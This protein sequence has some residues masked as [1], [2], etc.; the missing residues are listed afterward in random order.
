MLDA[1]T[2]KNIINLLTH[3]LNGARIEVTS[4]I[5]GEVVTITPHKNTKAHSIAK[6][7]QAATMAGELA[8][9]V[10][11]LPTVPPI[12]PVGNRPDKRL[13]DCH[14]TLNLA[15]NQLQESALAMPPN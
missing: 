12:T 5:F 4:T 14:P 8:E 9:G 6:T 10:D 15:G 3:V 7:I 13:R 1:K 2:M 11:Y